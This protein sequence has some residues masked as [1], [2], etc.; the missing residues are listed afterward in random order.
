MNMK[1]EMPLQEVFL[2]GNDLI[3]LRPHSPPC[4]CIHSPAVPELFP[5]L[6]HLF[7]SPLAVI[8]LLVCSWLFLLFPTPLRACVQQRWDLQR[9]RMV[10]EVEV[11][12]TGEN[13]GTEKSICSTP[14]WNSITFFRKESRMVKDM[15]EKGE[16][17]SICKPSSH[18]ECDNWLLVGFL[19]SYWMGTV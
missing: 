12:R 4:S 10:R 9:R 17:Q 3:P 19:C 13:T 15:G 18:S 14:T 5:H 8:F 7:L 2:T 1:R 6:P 11:S 16:I